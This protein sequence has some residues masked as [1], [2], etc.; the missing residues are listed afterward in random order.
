MRRMLRLLGVLA[1]A[2]V[3]GVT[4]ALLV[5]GGGGRVR[6]GCGESDR[7]HGGRQRDRGPDERRHQ[8]ARDLV[9]PPRRRRGLLSRSFL[10]SG[11]GEGVRCLVRHSI[12]PLS[13]TSLG[14]LERGRKG[15]GRVMLP[16][17][18]GGQLPSVRK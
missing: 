4:G 7:S 2:A 11:I 15:E 6:G 16:G 3:I 8:Q 9:S 12:N 17:V 13:I 14:I 5:L 1:N 18:G 10:V